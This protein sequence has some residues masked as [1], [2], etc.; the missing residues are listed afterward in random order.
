MASDRA[1][2]LYEW[3]VANGEPAIDELIQARESEAYFLDFKRSSDNGGGPR[4]ST[5]DRKNLAKAISGFGNSEGGVIVW[6]VECS[7][8]AGQG[9]V[10]Q[11]KF[12]L[13]DAAAFRSRLEG[14]VS[15]CTVPGHERVVSHAIASGGTQGYVI[16]YIPKSARAPHQT[17]RDQRYFMRAG[18]AFA[19]V[20]HGVLEGM[21]GR[22]PQPRVFP[23]YVLSLP[24][25]AENHVSLSC[26]I[27]V[28]NEGPG[29]ARDI[30]AVVTVLSEPGPNCSISREL[31]DEPN[32][33]GGTV[34]DTRVS[35][36]SKDGYKIPPESFVQPII[37]NFDFARPIQS[38]LK[39]QVLVGC[40]GSAPF[41]H[42]WVNSCQ[43]IDAAFA[44]VLNGEL[45]DHA[46]SQGL[47]GTPTEPSNDPVR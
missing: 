8:T 18:S 3:L 43:D 10:A 31:P 41:R 9:D 11:A 20:P 21:F 40:D 14:I 6:G 30:Y 25:V 16:T 22:R 29:M 1:Q 46:A 5:N 17:I 2:D 45:T 13:Q 32:W 24:E 4:L 26:G 36:A 35:L 19:S 34:F 42:D 39:V 12:P 28:Y 23:T 44:A 47:L 15:G 27:S 7:G 38:D 37:L 33:V